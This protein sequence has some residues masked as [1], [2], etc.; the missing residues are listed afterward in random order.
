MHLYLLE[1]PLPPARRLP[2]PLPPTPLS[3]ACSEPSACPTSTVCRSNASACTAAHGDDGGDDDDEDDE[4]VV[5]LL[6]CCGCAR[7]WSL[8]WPLTLL[9][10]ADLRDVD[11]DEDNNEDDDDDD[12]DDD[13]DNDDADAEAAIRCGGGGARRAMHETGDA[14]ADWSGIARQ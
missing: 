5:A 10:E 12:D 14:G 6:V 3:K 9:P 13:A 7:R 1:L 2:L 8:A 4:K 11:D